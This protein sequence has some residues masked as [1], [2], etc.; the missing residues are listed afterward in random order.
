MGCVTLFSMCK[1][2][3]KDRV[4]GVSCCVKYSINTEFSGFHVVWEEYLS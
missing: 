2:Q 3:H 4:F 1:V